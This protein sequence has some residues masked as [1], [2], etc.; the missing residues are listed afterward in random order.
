MSTPIAPPPSAMSTSRRASSQQII[1]YQT[2]ENTRRASN[3][4]YEQ[5]VYFLHDVEKLELNILFSLTFECK[6][7]YILYRNLLTWKVK[8]VLFFSLISLV[9]TEKRTTYVNFSCK[10]FSI[11]NNYWCIPSTNFQNS[12]A[13][14]IKKTPVYIIY[15]SN[16]TTI[17]IL[18]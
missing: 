16:S 3:C 18:L 6:N 15:F 14:Y 10:N 12:E 17:L 8:I 11:E 1:E 4:Q 2:E 5:Q 7:K 13:F 9:K